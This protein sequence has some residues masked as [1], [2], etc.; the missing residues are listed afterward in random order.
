MVPPGTRVKTFRH[1]RTGV[2]RMT[3]VSLPINGMPECRVVTYTPS[4][5]ESRRGLDLLLAEEG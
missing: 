1:E 3:S 4:D 2:L 5:E